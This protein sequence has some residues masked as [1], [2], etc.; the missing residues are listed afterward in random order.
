MTLYVTETIMEIEEYF[1]RI[2]YVQNVNLELKEKQT[3]MLS[4]LFI[5]KTQF[6]RLAHSMDCRVFGIIFF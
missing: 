1:L 3:K 4:S 6:I 5:N 2:C